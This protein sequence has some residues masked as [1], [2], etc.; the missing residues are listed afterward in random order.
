MYTHEIKMLYTLAHKN[1][2]RYNNYNYLRLKCFDNLHL[3]IICDMLNLHPTLKS[4]VSQI[5]FV[6]G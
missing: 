3:I 6:V 5:H 2:F 4:L 1:Y